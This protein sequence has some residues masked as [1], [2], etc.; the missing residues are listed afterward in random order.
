MVRV[1]H[2]IVNLPARLG[3]T[4]HGLTRRLHSSM[5]RK[6]GPEPCECETNLLKTTSAL[7]KVWRN[8]GA[9]E[10]VLVTPLTSTLQHSVLTEVRPSAAP[11]TDVLTYHTP[12]RDDSKAWGLDEEINLSSR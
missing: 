3:S 6:V 10:S 1:Y 12:V 4:S 8:L 7:V 11:D 2:G 9:L 5:V